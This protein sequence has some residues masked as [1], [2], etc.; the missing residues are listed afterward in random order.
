MNNLGNILKEKNEL[1]EA[2]ELLTLA[3]QIQY[4]LNAKI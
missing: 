3:V 1:H 2:E 4:V